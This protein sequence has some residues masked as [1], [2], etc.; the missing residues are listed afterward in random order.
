MH[1]V[2][3]FDELPL[4]DATKLNPFV[5]RICKE[6]KKRNTD[7]KGYVVHCVFDK[8]GV[9]RGTEYPCHNFV[10]GCMGSTKHLF[11]VFTHQACTQ[12]T[13]FI[14]Y[15]LSS[16]SPYA[17]LWESNNVFVIRDKESGRPELIYWNNIPEEPMNLL[18]NFLICTRLQAGWGLSPIW[19]YLVDQ[20]F[21]KAVA[22][23]LMTMFSWGNQT[24]T[25]SNHSDER[26]TATPEK[27]Y[28]L[29]V[30]P[31]YSGDQPFNT[32]DCFSV[33]NFANS[34]MGNKA[35]LT[36]KQGGSGRPCNFIWDSK[37]KSTLVN[38]CN[39]KNHLLLR[40]SYL[41]K[42]VMDTKTVR[43]IEKDLLKNA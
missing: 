26:H 8:D 15:L 40:D 37:S 30:S 12:A 39:S 25:F 14:D 36:F 16:E 23:A 24:V 34:I 31:G 4:D 11:N 9:F 43:S 19:K 13:E 1:V 38:F 35:L 3:S 33:Y 29:E 21:N 2:N 5:Q 28:L 7:Y 41:K 20:G 10:V 6:Y 17:K 42:V 18:C 27:Q 32:I 22:T